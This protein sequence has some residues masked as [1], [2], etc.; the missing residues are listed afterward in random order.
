MP[1]PMEPD[2]IPG[3]HHITAICSSAAQNLDFY[4]R[5]LGLRLVKQTVNF[6]DPFTYH[7]YYGDE[8]GTPGTILTFFP[9]PDLPRG[10]AGAGMVSAIA[11]D[12]PAAGLADWQRHLTGQGID[13]ATG[14]RFEA[15]LLR[16]NDPDGLALELI[17]TARDPGVAGTAGLSAPPITGFHSAS[18]RLADGDATRALMVDTLGMADVGRESQRLRFTMQ[19]RQAPGHFIDLVV[20][21]S[22]GRRT[23]GTGT[24]HHI[25]FRT[26]DDRQQLAWQRRLR[27]RG[28]AVTEVRDRSYFR[29]IYFHAPGG[30]LFEIATDPP[31]FTIDEDLD[32]LGSSLKL[33]DRYEPLRGRIESTLPSLA[34]A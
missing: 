29:S 30:V 27:G 1:T 16:F 6:D 20:D 28:V 4:S 17:G 26:P 25:A 14:R 23:S 34:A 3:I 13:V 31:G 18:I 10:R 22:A 21:S 12:V 32:R 19:D 8:T 33:P 24:V 9:W 11:F 15:P 2:P 5:I 7:L